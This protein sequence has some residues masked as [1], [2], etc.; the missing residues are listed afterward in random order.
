MSSHFISPPRALTVL[1][2]ATSSNVQKVM[3]L[4]DEIGYPAQLV[5]RIDIGGKYGKNKEPA[6]LKQ[7]PNG[8]V[9]TLLDGSSVVWESNSILR[10]VVNSFG[11]GL[12]GDGLYPA[13]AAERSEVERWMD[14][15]L[16][17]IAPP[18]SL[19]YQQLIRFAPEQR[20]LNAILE[21]HQKASAAL[22][23]LDQHLASHNWVAGEHYSLA[24]CCLGSLVHR[25]FTLPD[26]VPGV[27]PEQSV[28]LPNVARWY[29]QL[30]QRRSFT[31]H[32]MLAF[33]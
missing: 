27:L 8:V 30:K 14:W 24:E 20:N 15:H 28:A 21:A 22:L 10:Y 31:T 11:A 29:E 23:L 25:W 33:E 6:Y 26:V 7:N 13:R 12:Q 2:R 3:V 5:Q 4:L 16:S 17:V 1:G 19:I 9:P 18:M 32:V